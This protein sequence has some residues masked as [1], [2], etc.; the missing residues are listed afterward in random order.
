MQI[1]HAVVQQVNVPILSGE[2][3]FLHADPSYLESIV[4]LPPGTGPSEDLHSTMID[5]DPITGNTVNAAKRIQCLVRMHNS[6][7]L[8]PHAHDVLHIP[9]FWVEDRGII[10]QSMVDEFYTGPNGLYTY[11]LYARLFLG[12]GLFL[13]GI[14]LI[15]AIVFARYYFRLR[16]LTE[17]PAYSSINTSDHRY[18]PLPGLER[19]DDSEAGGSK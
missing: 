5:V 17:D 8:Y 14:M 15:L 4:F 12:N 13:A 16:N 6:M 11:Q 1:F 10:S 18:A 3:Y 19:P 9:L 7:L 2:P